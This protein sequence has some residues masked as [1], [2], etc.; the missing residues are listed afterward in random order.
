METHSI[1]YT[2]V[3]LSILEKGAH[4]LLLPQLAIVPIRT[5]SLAI[6]DLASWLDL[7]FSNHSFWTLG[8]S[9]SGKAYIISYHESHIT[10][11]RRNTNLLGNTSL[12]I[13]CYGVT[14]LLYAF[15]ELFCSRQNTSYD[16]EMASQEWVSIRHLHLASKNDS[17]IKTEK[18]SIRNHTQ[19]EV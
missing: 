1:F 8:L 18:K 13:Y 11:A 9:A 6:L 5:C 19:G 3:S 4:L 16:M 7:A 17:P 14:S 2:D 10:S 12:R 15:L